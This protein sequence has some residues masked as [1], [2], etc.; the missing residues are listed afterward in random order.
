MPINL[1]REIMT[2]QEMRLKL[3]SSLNQD[4]ASALE[5]GDIWVRDYAVEVDVTTGCNSRRLK[6][7][8]V[9]EAEGL[10]VRYV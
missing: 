6:A 9:L 2:E 1:R 10:P 3:D 4:V 7:A 5:S 8:A